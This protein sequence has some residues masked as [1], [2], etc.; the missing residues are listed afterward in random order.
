MKHFASLTAEYDILRQTW[1]LPLFSQHSPASLPRPPFDFVPMRFWAFWSNEIPSTKASGFFSSPRQAG[2]KR[3]K[4]CQHRTNQTN[5]T[6]HLWPVRN[7]KKSVLSSKDHPHQPCLSSIGIILYGHY[8]PSISFACVSWNTVKHRETSMYGLFFCFGS[9][10]ASTIGQ[11]I[12]GRIVYFWRNQ[13]HYIRLHFFAWHNGCKKIGRSSRV[14]DSP[15][16]HVSLLWCLGSYDSHGPCSAFLILVVVMSF[17][18][19]SNLPNHTGSE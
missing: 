14:T 4:K 13:V 1:F 15:L 19:H 6:H 3:T 12:Q 7:V 17:P 8:S 11:T 5:Q 16:L 9:I 18:E 2:S 10:G